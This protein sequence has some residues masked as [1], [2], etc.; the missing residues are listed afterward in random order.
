M[1]QLL[2]KENFFIFF[3]PKRAKIIRKYIERLGM[4]KV[5]LQTLIFPQFWRAAK[6]KAN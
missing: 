1:S 4:Q 6:R 3:I 5:D 2:P